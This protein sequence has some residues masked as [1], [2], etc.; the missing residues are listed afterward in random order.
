MTY[1]KTLYVNATAEG[2]TAAACV[3]AVW[4]Y[5][6]QNTIAG[7]CERR[8][9]KLVVSADGSGSDGGPWFCGSYER[10]KLRAVKHA[11][12][13][14][15]CLPVY[16]AKPDEDPFDTPGP[17]SSYLVCGGVDK[18]TNV[19]CAKV[20][21]TRLEAKAELRKRSATGCRVARDSLVFE[22][23]EEEVISGDS[24]DE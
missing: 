2:A 12:Q 19:L 22:E 6:A 17:P 14:V 18:E 7:F 8:G 1:A 9:E 4:R 15:R 3:E 16:D 11:L 13:E 24:H 20:V 21:L 10:A 5:V 23:S